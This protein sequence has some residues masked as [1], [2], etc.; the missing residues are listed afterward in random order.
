[1]SAAPSGYTIAG[2]SSTQSTDDINQNGTAED[3][4]WFIGYTPDVVVATWMGY[5]SEYNLANMALMK[6]LACLRPKCRE[7]FQ[8]QMKRHLRSSG[9]NACKRIK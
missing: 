3:D 8:Q 6:A 9:F 1:M 2:K 4:H 7:S 5:D